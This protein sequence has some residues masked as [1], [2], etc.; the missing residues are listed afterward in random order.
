[1]AFL[2]EID[3]V[4]I[5]T[6]QWG[7]VRDGVDYAAFDEIV[8]EAIQEGADEDIQ[9]NHQYQDKQV[10][11][12]YQDK[13]VNHQYQDK[14]VN[15]QYQDKHVNHKYQDKQVNHQ[16]QDKQVNHKYQDKQGRDGKGIVYVFSAGNDND[17]YEDA[18]TES[19]GHTPET[20]LVG[21]LSDRRWQAS[22]STPGSGVMI[23]AYSG[24]IFPISLHN[25]IAANPG[26]A[27]DT[28]GVQGTSFSAP[29]VTAAI[30]LTLQA[31]PNLTWRDVQHI[32]IEAANMNNLIGSPIF[33]NNAGFL[34]N[35]FHGFGL[36]DAEAMVTLAQSW[37]NVGP[38]VVCETGDIEVNGAVTTGNITSSHLL[39]ECTIKRLE[40]I[41]VTIFFDTELVGNV[42]IVLESPTGTRSRLMRFQPLNQ[43]PSSDFFEAWDYRTVQ[44]WGEDPAGTWNLYLID[45][46]GT[47]K[48]LESWRMSLNGAAAIP[49]GM[50]GG[51]CDGVGNDECSKDALAACMNG[52]CMCSQG[53]H[54]VAR[55]CKRDNQLGGWCEVGTPLTDPNTK[56]FNGIVFCATGYSNINGTCKKD[57]VV[58]GICCV[59]EGTACEKD[60]GAI[61]VCGVCECPTGVPLQA[62]GFCRSAT[63]APATMPLPAGE[64]GG[65][66]VMGRCNRREL[67]CENNVCVPCPD[68]LRARTHTRHH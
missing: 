8:L 61:C 36:V 7:L 9:V 2:H 35:Y 50:L 59:T 58:G 67:Q 43:N 22:Y 51:P 31:N 47:E 37:E 60:P 42:E 12:Q 68:Q 38:E 63:P 17:V 26:D 45:K 6:N 54:Q 1:M 27:C 56:C 16:N 57:G 4:D 28:V 64:M 18:N 11:H 32:L 34:F 29:L 5:S 19:I 52:M 40:N 48:Q 41:I 65:M 21:A 25:L 53:T 24:E 3:E 15:H 66:C 30:A 46:D 39:G 13:Q 23:T 44:F 20:I 10:N 33:R 14:Q 62:N 55:T 49:A